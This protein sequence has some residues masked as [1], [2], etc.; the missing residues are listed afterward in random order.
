MALDDLRALGLL[1][2]DPQ[3]ELPPPFPVTEML[4][5]Y[6]YWV[7]S[8]GNPVQRLGLRTGLENPT[9]TFALS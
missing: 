4:I 5:A 8:R 9:A 7:S 2:Q 3:R 1:L 6:L